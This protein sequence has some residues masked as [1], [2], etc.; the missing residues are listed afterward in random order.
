M[1]CIGMEYPVLQWFEEKAYDFSR[2]MNP[3]IP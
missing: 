1:A 2:G 3:T